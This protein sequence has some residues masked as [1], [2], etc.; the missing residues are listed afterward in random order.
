VTQLPVTAPTLNAS[1]PI[2]V[3]GMFLWTGGTIGSLGSIMTLLANGG[4]TLTGAGKSF[5]G[6]MIVNNST[7]VWTAGT[8]TCNNAAIFSNAPTAL[9]DLQA[10]GTVAT[11]NS[12]APLLANS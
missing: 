2:V 5:S 10:D 12:G 8:I 7:A 4:I 6:G 9:F 11:L 3:P 1:S